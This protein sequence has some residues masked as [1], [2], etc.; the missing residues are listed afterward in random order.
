MKLGL[1]TTPPEGTS[2]AI[3]VASTQLVP[4]MGSCTQVH[5]TLAPIAENAECR[6]IATNFELVVLGQDAPSIILGLPSL[7]LLGIGVFGL[8]T[9]HPKVAPLKPQG[10]VKKSSRIDTIDSTYWI[11]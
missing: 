11:L 7:A 3:Q 8:P 6:M 2:K 4:R 9:S 10:E 1:T 5:V